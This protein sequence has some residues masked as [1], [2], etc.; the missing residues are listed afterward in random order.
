M[1][2]AV[3]VAREKVPGEK[4]LVAYYVMDSAWRGSEEHGTRE[5]LKIEQV[6]GWA[7]TFDAVCDESSV[8]DPTFNTAGWISS[9]YSAR[10]FRR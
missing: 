5:A 7:T 8:A 9:W 3:I 2:E 6:S 4:H 1:A 10:A